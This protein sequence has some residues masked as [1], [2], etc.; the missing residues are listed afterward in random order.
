M[1]RVDPRIHAAA[2]EAAKRERTSLNQ[3]AARVLA[4]AAP[5]GRSGVP[6]V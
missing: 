4:E 2:L 5:A 3:W 6:P 1:L